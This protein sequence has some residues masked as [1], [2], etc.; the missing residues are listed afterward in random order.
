VGLATKSVLNDLDRAGPRSAGGSPLERPSTA[1][2][3]SLLLSAVKTLLSVLQSEPMPPSTPR[4]MSAPQAA[5]LETIA[6]RDLQGKKRS[7]GA[8]VAKYG[9]AAAPR[10]KFCTTRGAVALWRRFWNR[11]SN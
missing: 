2:V 9:S 6:H 8:H 4:K 10:A 11:L 1:P 5:H 7:E 3:L